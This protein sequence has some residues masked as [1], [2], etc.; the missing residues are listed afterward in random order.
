[1]EEHIPNRRLENARAAFPMPKDVYVIAFIDTTLLGSGKTG[2]AI[3]DKGLFW[4]NGNLTGFSK[5]YISWD[6]FS[7]ES[8]WQEGKRKVEI[9]YDNYFYISNGSFQIERVVQLLE[10]IHDSFTGSTGLNLDFDLDLDD[11]NWERIAAELEMKFDAE[12]ASENEE[13]M[14]AVAGQQYGP[15]EL[16]VIREMVQIK[17]VR[18][19]NTHVWKPGMPDW[20]EFSKQPEMAALAAPSVSP[21]PLPT[22]QPVI[23]PVSPVANPSQDPLLATVGINDEAPVD[24]N[25][26][27]EEHL[28]ELPGIGIVGAKRILQERDVNGG[29]Q[30]AEQVGEWLGLKPHQVDKLKKQTIFRPSATK[31]GSGRMVDY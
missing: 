1:M 16:S 27:T 12:D 13:W 20:I 25:Q 29:F 23:P 26:A 6:D 11:D 8:V 10:E 4:R 17:Q 24:F 9:G 2:L 28:Q 5:T 18:P 15:F 14:L 31:Q 21:P 3:T 22:A 30:S 19:E 7:S